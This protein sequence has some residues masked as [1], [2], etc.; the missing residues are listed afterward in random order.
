MMKIDLLYFEDC[1]SW[2]AAL[3]NL[4]TALQEE[5][6]DVTVNLVEVTSD[7]EALEHQFLGSPSFQ[8]DGKDFWPASQNNY[9]LSCRVYP[10]AEGM[11]GWPSVVMLRQKL[12][13]SN[14]PPAS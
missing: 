11:K 5:N 2:Q 6:L 12:H 4:Q 8:I 9:S 10:T 7:Q 1:P 14:L 13:E 3:I